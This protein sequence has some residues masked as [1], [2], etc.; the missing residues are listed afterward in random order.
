MILKRAD[1]DMLEHLLKRCAPVDTGNLRDNGIQSAQKI[2]GGYVIQIGT[3][4]TETGAPATE[5][6]ALF[7]EIKNKSSLGWVKHC[8]ENWA[9]TM[10][11]ILTI[12]KEGSVYQDDL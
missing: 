6:Y 12:R 9:N 11:T 8:C 1:A 2:P 3:E 7:T 5:D 4:A 10:E